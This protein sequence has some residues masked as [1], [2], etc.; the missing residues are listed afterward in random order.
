MKKLIFAIL[1]VM[2]LSTPVA[3]FD[4]DEFTVGQYVDVKNRISTSTQ[5]NARTTLLKSLLEE[6]W[7]NV[8]IDFNYTKTMKPKNNCYPQNIDSNTLKP[9]VSKYLVYLADNERAAFYRLTDVFL[10]DLAFNLL[11]QKFPC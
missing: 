8:A 11:K 3:A 9:I 5:N 1:A 6:Y 2:M 4:G 10:I 7:E